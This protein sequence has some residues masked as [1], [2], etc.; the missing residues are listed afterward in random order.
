[1]RGVLADSGVESAEQLAECTPT[2]HPV[3]LIAQHRDGNFI[4]KKKKVKFTNDSLIQ[5]SVYLVR[6]MKM[7][8]QEGER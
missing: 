3:E 4:A 2:S 8:K 1:M 6:G 5:L 7:L